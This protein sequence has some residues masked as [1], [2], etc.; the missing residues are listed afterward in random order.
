MFAHLFLRLERRATNRLM[1]VIVNRIRRILVATDRSEAAQCAEMRAAMLG[2]ELNAAVHEF[3]PAQE[4]KAG[5]R[6]A[7]A[8]VTVVDIRRTPAIAGRTAADTIIMHANDMDADLTVVAARE[9]RLL[10]GIFAEHGD[11]ELVRLSHR[12]ILLVR[13]DASGSYRKVLVAVDFSVEAREAARMALAIAPSA[14]FIFLHAFRVPHE[15]MMQQAGVSLEVI[16]G[17]RT[18]AREAARAAL[19][20]F[21]EGLG[22]RRQLI[23]RSIQHGSPAMVINAQARQL[24]ADLIAMGK[25]GRSRFVELLLGSVARSVMV[26]SGCD[27]LFAS[28][29]GQPD[30]DQPPAA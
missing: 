7:T 22:P 28:Q 4:A 8:L 21:I 17:H 19:N 23:S 16:Y 25:H 29:N 24:D 13:S 20:S 15:E 11:D 5:R 6:V 9:R 26:Q 1:E 2:T 10:D 14:H 27:V 12:P 18:Q 3:S 30:W